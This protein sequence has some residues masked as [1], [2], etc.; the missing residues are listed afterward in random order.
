MDSKK[1]LK[2]D[3]ETALKALHEKIDSLK[4]QVEKLCE[5]TGDCGLGGLEVKAPTTTTKEK[6]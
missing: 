3:V 6:K 1:I 2:D 5:T 4:A